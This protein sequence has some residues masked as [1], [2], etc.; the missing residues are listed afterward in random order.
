MHREVVLVN[1]KPARRV[2]CGTCKRRPIVASA[3]FHYLVETEFEGPRRKAQALIAGEAPR[4]GPKGLRTK[5]QLQPSLR[6]LTDLPNIC[7]PEVKPPQPFQQPSSSEGDDACAV[8][9]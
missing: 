1:D 3:T 2:S 5:S 6:I 8:V 4:R 9:E 7:Q